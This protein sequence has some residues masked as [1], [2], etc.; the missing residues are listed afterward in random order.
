MMAGRSES[1]PSQ[2]PA[3]TLSSTLANTLAW[4][5]NRDLSSHLPP[6]LN[7]IFR[8]SGKCSA[9]NKG[10]LSVSIESKVWVQL[11]HFQPRLQ[12]PTRKKS[13][14]SCNRMI[15]TL[16]GSSLTFSFIAFTKSFLSALALSRL[17]IL[18]AWGRH[19][20]QA[21]LS[22]AEFFTVFCSN[23]DREVLSTPINSVSREIKACDAPTP[24]TMLL[25]DG[26]KFS[27]S[28]LELRVTQAEIQALCWVS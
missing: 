18:L 9:R 23:T 16:F 11:N 7:V 2:Y 17:I 3:F 5:R 19:I 24:K 8:F 21:L 13:P 25:V 14:L 27:R 6:R 20:V 1:L 4:F 26:F 10:T 15:P 12:I 28:L 22:I